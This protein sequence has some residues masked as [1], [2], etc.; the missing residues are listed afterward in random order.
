MRPTISARSHTRRVPNV[1]I[2]YSDG[3]AKRFRMKIYYVVLFGT[4]TVGNIVVGTMAC[5]GYTKPGR[6]TESYV[7]TVKNRQNEKFLVF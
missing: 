6:Q 5:F 7:S 3:S 2:V 4:I 1:L